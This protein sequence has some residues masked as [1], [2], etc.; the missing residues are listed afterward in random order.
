MPSKPAVVFDADDTT[1]WTYDMEDGAMKFNFD[2]ALQ[3]TWVQDEKFAAVPGMP[4]FVA[5]VADA[6]C[7]VFGLTGRNTGQKYATLGN[8]SKVGYSDFRANR[9]YTKWVSG[10]T[11]PAYIDCG[12]DNTCST[13]EYKSQT[14]AHI[15]DTGFDIVANLG[16]QFSDLIGGSADQ[17]YKLPNPTYYLP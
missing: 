14:R 15:E 17:V 11:P 3:D 4:E 5:D 7:T 10:A 16:D 9:Y 8:L 6:G 13:I 2:P 12:A 1:L